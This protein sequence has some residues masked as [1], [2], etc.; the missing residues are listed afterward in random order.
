MKYIHADDLAEIV[1]SGCQVLDLRQKA[2]GRR[3]CEMKCPSGT[4]M[5]S[6]TPKKLLFSHFELVEP[7]FSPPPADL[8]DLLI[9]LTWG[10][11][12]SIQPQD[13]KIQEDPKSPLLV[14]LRADIGHTLQ[15]AFLHPEL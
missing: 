2:V 7:E 9:F 1:Q 3:K 13:S 10:L 5:R 12:C 11:L 14:P 6:I 4:N 15:R 8:L